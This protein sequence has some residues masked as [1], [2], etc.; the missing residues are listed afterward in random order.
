M[1]LER[2]DEAGEEQATDRERGADVY[3]FALVPTKGRLDTQGETITKGI[4]IRHI[5]Q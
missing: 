4:G 5:R 1:P 3:A 2:E